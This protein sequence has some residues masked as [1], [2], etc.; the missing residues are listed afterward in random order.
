MDTGELIDCMVVSRRNLSTEAETYGLDS[1]GNINKE[2]MS[3]LD[4]QK[5]DYESI[6]SNLG[7]N[8]IFPDEY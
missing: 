4:R 2:Y 1:A 8:F 7:I 3:R 5:I 6:L